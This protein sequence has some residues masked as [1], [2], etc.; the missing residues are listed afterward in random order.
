MHYVP[1]SFGYQEARR[2]TTLALHI[3]WVETP[4]G[5]MLVA[6]EA[7]GVFAQWTGKNMKRACLDY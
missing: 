7:Q 5:P 1:G 3:A 2:A 6:T 4:I